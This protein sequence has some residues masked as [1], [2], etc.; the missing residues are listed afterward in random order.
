LPEV[1]ENATHT[2]AELGSIVGKQHGAASGQSGEFVQGSWQPRTFDKSRAQIVPGPQQMV[3]QAWAESQ[4]CPP[5]HAC[6]ATH[7]PPSQGVPQ[8]PSTQISSLAQQPNPQTRPEQPPVV[9]LLVPPVAPLE[10]DPPLDPLEV[11]EVPVDPERLPPL[12]L[13]VAEAVVNGWLDTPMPQPH[14]ASAI[15]ASFQTS[16]RVT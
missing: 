8:P 5:T 13:P 10:V 1:L 16:R 2:P 6:P 3:S 11:E 15:H 12:L 4:H 9:E 7:A 14:A